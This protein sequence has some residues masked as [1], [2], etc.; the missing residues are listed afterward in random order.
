VK[1]EQRLIA[2]ASHEMRTTAA[3]ISAGVEL[4]AERKAVSPA[5]RQLLEDL[6]SESQRLNRMVGDLLKGSNL[7]QETSLRGR[8]SADL[9]SVIE[10]AS[11]RVTLLAPNRVR[12][13]TSLQSLHAT[14]ISV[15]KTVLESA[16]DALLENA[17]QHAQGRVLV[18][19]EIEGRQ[20]NLFIDDDGPGISPEHRAMV[21]QPFARV[22]SHRG[23]PGS[24][25]GLAI[26]C[27]AAARLGGTLSIEDSPL[28][29]A[30]LRLRFEPAQPVGTV[31]IEG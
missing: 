13:E 22:E 15:P 14:Q 31:I 17:V 8:T 11:R 20:V 5:Q 21:M 23:T 2:D 29:G 4:L 27:S 28:G 30:R 9:R 1:R 16:L 25:L 6:Q 18:G 26:A 19:C 7:P 24:G 3:V 12:V 10:Q